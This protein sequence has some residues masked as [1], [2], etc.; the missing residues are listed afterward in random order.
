[1]TYETDKID[2]LRVEV[3]NSQWPEEKK[4]AFLDYQDYLVAASLSNN[5]QKLYSLHIH[6]LGDFLP[7][8][9]FKDYTEQ[10]MMAYKNML[11]RKYS[12]YN[13]HNQIL[14]VMTFLKR[15]LKLEKKPDCLKW[16]DTNK[17]RKKVV[18]KLNPKEVLQSEEIKALITAAGSR[19][20]KAIIFCLW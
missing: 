7:K 14:D 8:K 12:P 15:H 3:R 2:R 20:N 10:D 4:R 13:V 16:Y 19:R 1:M 18:K 9:L 17:H 6:R 5:T 11:A